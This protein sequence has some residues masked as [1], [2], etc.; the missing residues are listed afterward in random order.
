MTWAAA[1]EH[2]STP[3]TANHRAI[4][5]QAPKEIIYDIRRIPGEDFAPGE[6]NFSMWKR[7]A[8]GARPKHGD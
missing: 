6:G 4:N 3:V 7:S 8:L 1:V 5:S 2:T